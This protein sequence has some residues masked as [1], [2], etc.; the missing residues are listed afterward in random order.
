MRNVQLQN[1]VGLPSLG[2]GLWQVTER[3]QMYS[4]I[5]AAYERGYRLF[6]TA[7]AYSNEMSLGAAISKQGIPREQIFL[8]DKAWNTSRGYEQVQAACKKSLRKLK[9]DYLDLYLLHWPASPKLYPNWKEINAETWGGMEALYKQGLVRAI[10]V[11]NFKVH[12]LQQLL[13]SADIVPMVDQIELHP[14]MPQTE[15]MAYC[16]E[17][18]IMPEASSPLGNGQIL[19]NGSLREVA[20]QLGRTVSQICLRWELQKGAIVIPKTSKIH[21]LS[22]NMDVFDFELTGEQMDQIDAIP[23][24]GGLAI[25]ADE[26][27]GFG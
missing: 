20:S 13:S 5:A 11:C 19:K 14:G 1:G 16:W 2:L 18:G 21:R 10:G 17:H 26:V 22:E 27:T 6:D 23:F 8:C 7:A 4:L 15:V 12:H 24:C 25:D 9:T 3:E